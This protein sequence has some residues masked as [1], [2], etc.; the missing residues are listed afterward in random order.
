[1]HETRRF[2][3]ALSTQLAL[4]DAGEGAGWH[5]RELATAHFAMITAPVEL[6]QMLLE[7]L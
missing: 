6:T 4:H 1:M 7:L 5:Y 2:G 3:L